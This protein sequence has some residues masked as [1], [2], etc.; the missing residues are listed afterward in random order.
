MASSK[1]VQG[2]MNQ[3]SVRLLCT[4]FDLLT[5]FARDKALSTSFH[6]KHVQVD[7]DTNLAFCSEPG[8]RVLR[9]DAQLIRGRLQVCGLLL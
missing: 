3:G 2:A 1:P 7:V 8:L 5:D 9:L 4:N 6:S